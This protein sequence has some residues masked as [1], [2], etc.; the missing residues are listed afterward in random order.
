LTLGR[1]KEE[2]MARLRE[3]TLGPLK[4]QQKARLRERPSEI[5]L[6]AAGRML[7]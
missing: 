7:K 1:L 5:S 3:L 2:Q 4:E 6:S